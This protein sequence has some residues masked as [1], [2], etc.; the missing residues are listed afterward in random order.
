[1][2]KSLNIVGFISALLMFSTVVMKAN[3]LRGAGIMMVLAGLGLSIYLPFYLLYRPG[4]APDP[5]KNRAGIVGAISAAVLNMGITFK[6]QHWPGAGVMI[7]LGLTTFALVFVPM[8]L[9]RKLKNE[10]SERQTFMNT[11][12]ASG[13][14]LFALGILFKLQ[15]WPGASIMLI[16]SVLF[17]FFGY[18]L[19]YLT[20][21]SIEPE[22]K[23]KYLHR[24]F[25]SVIIGCFVTSLILVA[26]NKPWFAPK[27]PQEVASK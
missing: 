23:T 10:A 25:M 26:L 21:K 14:T 18:F 22:A 9:R 12:G 3:H 5:G 11:L 15:H 7:V 1:M 2:K 4:E 6:F 16:M 24:A 27:S 8:A 17:L 19:L 20:D 13:L